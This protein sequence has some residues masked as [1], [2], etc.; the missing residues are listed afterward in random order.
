MGELQCV[1]I[2]MWAVV[3]WGRGGASVLQ[4]GE[5]TVLGSC[6]VGVQFRDV[7]VQGMVVRGSCSVVELQC[8]GVAVYMSC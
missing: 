1:A 4:Y 8:K 2:V 6:F 5:I 7:K 3:V